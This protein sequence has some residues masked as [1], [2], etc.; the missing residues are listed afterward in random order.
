MDHLLVRL[1]VIRAAAGTDS[2]SRHRAEFAPGRHLRAQTLQ[3]TLAEKD[4][5]ADK[6]DTLFQRYTELESIRRAEAD[7]LDLVRKNHKAEQVRRDTRSAADAQQIADLE[8][9]RDQALRHVEDSK[10]ELQRYRHQVRHPLHVPQN[11]LTALVARRAHRFS[12]SAK[13]R[14]E[15]TER[16]APAAGGRRYGGGGGAITRH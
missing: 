15:G 14:A 10:T 5:L 4:Q 6:Y 16:D 11:L 8:R 1:Q 12:N 13:Q 3:T 9:Q 2:G 7:E